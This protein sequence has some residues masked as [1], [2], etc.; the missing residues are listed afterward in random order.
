[1][2]LAV[3]SNAACGQQLN[4]RAEWAGMQ[5]APEVVLIH[6]CGLVVGELDGLACPFALEIAM[7]DCSFANNQSTTSGSNS[8]CAS[9]N[10]IQRPELSST[11]QTPPSFS[12]NE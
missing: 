7:R 10:S 5:R 2:V 1:L 8:L 4:L 11:R 9:V 6:R 12:K 3:N